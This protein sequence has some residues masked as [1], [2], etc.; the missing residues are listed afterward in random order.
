LVCVFAAILIFVSIFPPHEHYS[1]ANVCINNLR[2]IDLAKN[3][4]S[5]KFNKATNEVPTWDDIKPFLERG[6][7][8]YKFNPTNDLPICPLGGT[9]TIGKIGEPPTCSLSTTVTPAHVLP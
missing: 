6:K 8:F 7:P 5:L 2:N 3:I 1:S 4:W 9:Y